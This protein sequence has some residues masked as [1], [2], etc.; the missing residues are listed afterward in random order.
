[1][2]LIDELGFGIIFQN[3][4]FYFLN[5]VVQNQQGASA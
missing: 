5:A 1:M 2:H 4:F 3:D